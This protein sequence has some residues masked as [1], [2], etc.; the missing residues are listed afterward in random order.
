MSI[1]IIKSQIN[2][3]LVSK[4]PEVMAIKG[5]WGIG[6][7]YSWNKFLKE[8]KEGQ[9]IGLGMYS[10]ISLFGVNS[11]NEFKYSIFVNK[12]KRSEIGKDASFETFSHNL[13]KTWSILQDKSFKISAIDLA[14]KMATKN[15]ISN[16]TESIAFL[17]LSETIICIDDLE[18]RGKGLELKDVLGLVS[19]LKE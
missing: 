7:T 10:Y 17:S 19:L 13:N 9:K 18:R 12:I 15:S 3:F 6:K 4:E 16:I 1:E 8:A 5:S 11:L 2:K 14:S